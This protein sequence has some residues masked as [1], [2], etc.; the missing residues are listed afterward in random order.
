MDASGQSA[1]WYHGMEVF[2]AR[3]CFPARSV[4]VFVIAGLRLTCDFAFSQR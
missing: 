3:W 4:S 2:V 1:S